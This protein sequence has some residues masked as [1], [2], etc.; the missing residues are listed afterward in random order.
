MRYREHPIPSR[1]PDSTTRSFRGFFPFS[2]F[3][4]SMGDIPRWLPRH[5]VTLRPQGFT[6]SRRFIPTVTCWAYFIPVPL[7][8]FTLRGL[9]PVRGAVCPLRHRNPLGVET[10]ISELAP[11]SRSGTPERSR[12]STWGLARTLCGCPHGFAPLRGL[13]PRLAA[14]PLPKVRSTVPSRALSRWSQAD[15]LTGAPGYLQPKRN[16]SVSRRV[17]PLE[18]CYLVGVLDSSE[19]AECWRP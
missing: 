2:V 1:S 14:E 17:G 5:P 6:P 11:P 15:P 18:V 10:S 16:P 4:V 8:G 19:T 13:L 7:L 9:V 12:P 3:P